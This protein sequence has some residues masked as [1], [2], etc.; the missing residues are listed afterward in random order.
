MKPRHLAHSL[1]AAALLL[2]GQAALAVEPRYQESEAK[3]AQLRAQIER[4]QA[5]LRKDRTRQDEAAGEL[6]AL[7]ANIARLAVDLRSI[8]HKL[9][10]AGRRVDSLRRDIAAQQ[11][12]IRAHKDQ[13]ARQLR[14]AYASANGGFL[15]LLL[16]EEDPMRL[17]RMLAYHRYMQA[18][19]KQKMDASAAEIAKLAELEQALAAE[20]ASLQTLRDEELKAQAAMAAAR[21]ERLAALAAIEAAI[22]ARGQEISRLK[23]D[24]A[25]LESLLAKL[26]DV[27]ADVRDLRLDQQPFRTTRG[28]LEWPL[29]GAL[30]ARYGEQRGVGEM[31]W[32]GVLIGGRPG[33]PV[34]AV[35]RGHVV[36]ADWLRGFGLLLILDH[37]DGFMTLYGHND[38]IYKE[39]GD[40]V[41]PGEVIAAVGASG[42][43]R[44]PGLYFE[45]RAAG[46][47]VDPLQWL[48]VTRGR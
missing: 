37:G 13:L 1:A 28:R 20:T 5:E 31:R 39:N 10:E 15:R 9:G 16:S 27:L 33:E 26:R 30:L 34:R 2:C 3:L 7:D 22:S 24:A 35:A 17:A 38:A 23:A 45:V 32:S 47:P 14:A 6:Q 44:K 41:Q 40:W 21:E 46:K 36:F 42:G 25:G 29:K 11:A 19:H 12:R 8:E 48:R 4:L 43:Q 18:A